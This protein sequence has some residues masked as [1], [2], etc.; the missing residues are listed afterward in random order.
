[1]VLSVIMALMFASGSWSFRAISAAPPPPFSSAREMVVGAARA[2]R[3]NSDRIFFLIT[4]SPF[5]DFVLKR[6]MP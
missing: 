4:L 6:Q 2:I 3:I 1:M 5:I